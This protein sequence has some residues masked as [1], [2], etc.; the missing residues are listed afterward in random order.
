M[1]LELRFAV[2]IL[3]LWCW[4]CG[5][6]LRFGSCGVGAVVWEL[7]L[8]SCGW[9]LVAGALWL[10]PCNWSIV[11]GALCLEPSSW[12]LVAGDLVAG[13]FWLAPCDKRP[14]HWRLGAGD[15]KILKNIDFA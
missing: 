9:N 2:V 4:S 12:S 15:H 5:L 14:G 6:P 10:K 1:V 11:A 3:E 13:A 8:E 7:W